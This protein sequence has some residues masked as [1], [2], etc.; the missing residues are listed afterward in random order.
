MKQEMRAQ[1][2]ACRRG[3]RT[4][5]WAHAVKHELEQEPMRRIST[6]TFDHGQPKC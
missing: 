6:R 3:A 1:A 5:A 2:H 4:V